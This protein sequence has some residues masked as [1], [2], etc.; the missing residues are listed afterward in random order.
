MEE[1]KSLI[2]KKLND[3]KESSEYDYFAKGYEVALND[4]LNEL[5]FYTCKNCIKFCSNKKD[6]DICSDF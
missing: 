5:N 1:I 4:I 2:N 6:D 3:L